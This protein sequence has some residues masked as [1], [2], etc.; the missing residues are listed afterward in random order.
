MAVFAG[1]GR[2]SE[3]TRI[4]AGIRWSY[5]GAVEFARDAQEYSAEDAEDAE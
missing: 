1:S 5:A 4:S 2:P 3:Q